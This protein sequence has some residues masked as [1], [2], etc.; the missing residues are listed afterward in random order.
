VSLHCALQVYKHLNLTLEA[1]SLTEHNG[2]L[3]V[4]RGAVMHMRQRQQGCGVVAVSPRCGTDR[5]RSL[6]SS[7]AIVT[8]LYCVLSSFLSYLENGSLAPAQSNEPWTHTP[9]LCS[10]TECKTRSG[11][12]FKRRFVNQ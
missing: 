1:A 11:S 4:L 10:G 6:N 7:H 3:D 5:D 2:S 8:T 9:L 12:V